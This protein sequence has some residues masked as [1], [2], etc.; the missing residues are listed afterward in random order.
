MRGRRPFTP[1]AA[2]MKRAARRT[3]S[4]LSLHPPV[5]V[6]QPHHRRTCCSHALR[7]SSVFCG[8]RDKCFAASPLQQK[9]QIIFELKSDPPKKVLLVIFALHGWVLTTVY[10]LI[11]RVL[12]L[13]F[14]AKSYY[15][16]SNIVSLSVHQKKG[17]QR[18]FIIVNRSNN[19]YSSSINTLLRGGKKS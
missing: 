1:P 10:P 15:K 14:Y 6:H 9:R 5:R 13:F 7:V 19:I 8:L 4:L 11:Q 16:Y 17:K 3:S 18:G 2:P 12:E